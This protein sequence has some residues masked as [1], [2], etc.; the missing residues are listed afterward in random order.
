MEGL[1]RLWNREVLGMSRRGW[2]S[3]PSS[4]GDIAQLVS[5]W[6]G[7][8]WGLLPPHLQGG[9]GLLS[10]PLDQAKGSVLHT[11]TDVT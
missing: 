8:G 3:T 6:M 4:S 10:E 11:V 1:G 9:T 5:A 2:P 7:L